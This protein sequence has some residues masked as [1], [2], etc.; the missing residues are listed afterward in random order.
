MAARLSR[1][2]T[3]PPI[4]RGSAAFALTASGIGLS[5]IT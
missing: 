3:K 5:A 1:E 4:T 2:M